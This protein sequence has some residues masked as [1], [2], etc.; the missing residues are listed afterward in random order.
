MGDACSKCCNPNQNEFVNE[1]KHDK[2][3]HPKAPP[4]NI[5]ENKDYKETNEDSNEIKD[6]TNANQIVYIYTAN[7]I[8]TRPKN[9]HQTTITRKR[10][11]DT[12]IL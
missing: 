1:A 8:K 11:Q 12:K 10:I 7:A 5:T 6:Y 9:T 3:T 4:S 2:I